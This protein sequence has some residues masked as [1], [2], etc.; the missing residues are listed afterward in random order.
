MNFRFAYRDSVHTYRRS[1]RVGNSLSLVQKNDLNLICYKPVMYIVNLL[2]R[3]FRI[4]V[5]PYDRF[6]YGGTV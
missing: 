2:N 4:F 1:A 6:I 5:S 3:L